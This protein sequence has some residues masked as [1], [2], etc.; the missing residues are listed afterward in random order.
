MR[1]HSLIVIYDCI[2]LKGVYEIGIFSQWHEK[3]E[4]ML[5]KFRGVLSTLSFHLEKSEVVKLQSRGNGERDRTKKEL[6][7]EGER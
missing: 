7:R 1:N 5:A 2:A 3:I 4:I 6:E